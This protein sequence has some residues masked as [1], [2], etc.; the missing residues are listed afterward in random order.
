MILL[1]CF[2]CIC[3]MYLWV[4][5]TCI[6]RPENEQPNWRCGMVFIRYNIWF[7]LWWWLVDWTCW[8]CTICTYNPNL[9]PLEVVNH[10]R[11]VPQ[12]ETLEVWGHSQLVLV[13]APVVFL[14]VIVLPMIVLFISLGKWWILFLS[15]V[16][17]L[18]IFD[19]GWSGWILP[20]YSGLLQ[21]VM[22]LIFI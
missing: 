20:I 18:V 5:S 15:V 10:N 3:I 8:M 13:I 7:L 22:N 11:Q 9:E 6:G 21:L 4:S 14:S 2:F 16:T 1:T 12:L 19:G 17:I